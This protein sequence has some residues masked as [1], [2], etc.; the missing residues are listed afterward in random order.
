MDLPAAIYIVKTETRI[1]SVEDLAGKKYRFPGD[2]IWRI[3]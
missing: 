2:I 1:H 3:S